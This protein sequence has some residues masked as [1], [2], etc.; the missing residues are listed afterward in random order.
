M[1]DFTHYLTTCL[2]V[3]SEHNQRRL[4]DEAPKSPS[5]R[6][7]TD[8]VLILKE[9]LTGPGDIC[10]L[11]STSTKELR[12]ELPIFWFVRGDFEKSFASAARYV[13]GDGDIF[14][15]SV[16]SF[17]MKRSPLFLILVTKC[18]GSRC[19]VCNKLP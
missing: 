15:R 5:P 14:M 1:F 7:K 2:C 10:N 13:L 17:E 3:Q 11:A 19:K 4:R 18:F 8:N 12:F 6:V 16:S 9:F